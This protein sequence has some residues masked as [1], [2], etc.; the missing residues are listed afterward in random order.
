MQKIKALTYKLFKF[1]NNHFPFDKGK[2]F[3]AR[4]LTR[5]F[6]SFQIKSKSGLKLEILLTST[7]DLHLAE[8]LPNDENDLI[9]NHI[10]KLGSDSI[11]IDIGSNIGF[12]SLL[13][14]KILSP[15]S[16]IYSFEPSIREF[17]RLL[18]NIVENKSTNIIPINFALSNINGIQ[19]FI[20]SQYHTGLNSL[21]NN[22]EETNSFQVKTPVIQFDDFC[23]I[24]N[25]EKIDL[26]K[27]DVE[28]AELFVLM[29]MRKN[30]LDK[31]IKKI[32]V[33]ITPK[34]LI[35]FSHSKQDLYEFMKI[36]GYMPLYNFEKWQYDE[37]FIP[38]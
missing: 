33:E 6:N 27:I 19:D 25:I 12:Y 10:N 8:I 17:R 15:K 13:A 23:Q 22:S 7:Q 35:N 14:S 21:S 2:H 29:G 9:L 31:K 28:G 32:I 5:V 30:L 34:F 38:I 36:V 16:R 20:I 26:I 1:Y 3:V 11:F 24:M 18:N 37:I 4:L